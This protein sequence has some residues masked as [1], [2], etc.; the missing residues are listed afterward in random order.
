MGE[1]KEKRGHPRYRVRGVRGSFLLT[2]D[3]RV[4]NLSVDGMSIETLS[5]LKVGRKYSLKLN[6][7]DHVL[8]VVG[9]VVWCT[10]VRTRRGRAG[11][12]VPIYR[13]GIHFEEVLGTRAAEILEFI[14][15][16]A[17]VSVEKR[18]FGR[19]KIDPD[20]PANVGCEAEFLVHELSFNGMLIETDLV[21]QPESVYTMEVRFNEVT[22]ET[23]GRVVR[24]ETLPEREAAGKPPLYLLGIEFVELR[25]EARV[26]LDKF[27]ASELP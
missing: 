26:T 3:A 4:V 15:E 5:P 14:E 11:D 18:L 6:Q 12:I 2:T 22:F 23:R 8:P 24:A 20:K 9:K 1:K 25:P 10:L 19:F 17:V 21:I 7:E 13:A 27:I 16:N